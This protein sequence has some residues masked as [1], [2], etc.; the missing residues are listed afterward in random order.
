MQCH[1]L[2]NT[3]T[4]HD[5][6]SGLSPNQKL[7]LL[8]AM[9]AWDN[10]AASQ[11]GFK[12][13]KLSLTSSRPPYL[14]TALLLSCICTRHLVERKSFQYKNPSYHSRKSVQRKLARQAKVVLCR[15]NYPRPPQKTVAMADFGRGT[16]LPD[17]RRMFLARC[18]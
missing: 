8:W 13:T 10:S 9:G 18:L 4:V 7:K 17:L 11:R 15:A 6:F 5:L 2:E 1:P 14:H 16:Y 3:A 12:A